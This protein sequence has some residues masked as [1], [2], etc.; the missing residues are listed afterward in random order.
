MSDPHSEHPAILVHLEY[1]RQGIDG[2]NERL[3]IQ[4]GRVRK[5]EQ[6]IAVLEDRATAATK[7]GAVWGGSIGAGAGAAIAALYHFIAG[8]Q[9]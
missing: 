3:D 1:L 7:A 9:K 2:I 6:S 8:A 4:N 5:N